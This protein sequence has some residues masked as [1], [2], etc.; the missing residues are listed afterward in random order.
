MR[1]VQQDHFGL[2]TVHFLSHLVD[3][4]AI[5]VY[6]IPPQCHGNPSAGIY[7]SLLQ[8]QVEKEEGFIDLKK[9]EQLC[10]VLARLCF[11]FKVWPSVSERTTGPDCGV[12]ESEQ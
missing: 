12:C 1:L 3:C 10:R 6:L 11:L 5:Y 9:H 2:Y 8:A 4:L 7:I